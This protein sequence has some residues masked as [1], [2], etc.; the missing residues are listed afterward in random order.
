MVYVR[1]MR[2]HPRHQHIL[3]R[4]RHD[5]RVDVA[6]LAVALDTSEVTIRRDL[7]ILAEQGTLRR[8]R[9]GAVSLMMRGEELPFAMREVEAAEAKERIAALASGLIRDGEAIVVDSGTS[10]LAVARALVDR[11]LT[12]MPLSLH[13][14]V[15]LGASSSVSLLLPGGTTRFGEGSMVGPIAEAGLAALRFDTV[16]LTCC[17]LS[18]EDGVTAHDLQDAAVK[19]AAVKYSRRTVVVA[20]GAKFTRTAL[21]SVC[22]AETIDILI[23]DETAPSAAL[24]QFRDAGVDVRVAVGGE[25]GP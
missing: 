17:G 3:D 6:E 24:D 18:A 4:L 9:G 15:A 2:G 16:V 23:T 1:S 12:V 20:E 19:R 8:I 5:G 22:P 25:D 11:K 13:G 7:D 10:G 21:A 14:A